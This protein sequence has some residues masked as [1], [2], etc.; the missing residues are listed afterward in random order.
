MEGAF[1]AQ[2]PALI[3]ELEDAIAS[4][5]IEKRI[6]A[7]WRITELFVSNA[8]QYTDEQVAL[9]DDVIVRIAAGLEV[10]TRKRLSNL[11]APVPNAPIR[12]VRALAFD[13]VIDVAAPMLQHSERLADA[14]L[15]DNAKTKSQDH[16]LAISQRRTLSEAVTDVLV[17]RG[18]RRVVRSV[19]QNTGA[20]FSDAGFS[21]LVER[22]S[23]DALLAER[24]GSRADIPR[25][26]FL[27]LVEQA[28]AQVRSRLAKLNPDAMRDI[29]A[30]LGELTGRIRDQLRNTSPLYRAARNRVEAIYRSGQLDAEQLRLFAKERRYEEAAVAL[31]LLAEQPVDMVERAML[32]EKPDMLLIL[33]KIAGLDTAGLRDV[34]RLQAADRGISEPDL[35]TTMQVYDRLKLETARRVIEFYQVRQRIAAETVVV[36][37]ANAETELFLTALEPVVSH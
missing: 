33:A 5:R 34:L 10:E 21:I 3:A 9:F 13:D 2:H 31:S 32:D 29:E 20:K 16:L 15:I 25:H 37:S 1:M 36:P 23:G 17:K 14:D 26:H 11:L 27:R 19:A 7:L 24:V 22:A 12:V 18:D 28:S 6:D 30:V 4:G 8:P 35:E